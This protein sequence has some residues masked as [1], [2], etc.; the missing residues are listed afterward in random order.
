MER[1]GRARGGR[2]GTAG[3]MLQF[4]LLLLLCRGGA[5]WQEAL[6]V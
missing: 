6:S 1:G 3:L 4:Y 2:E 5:S